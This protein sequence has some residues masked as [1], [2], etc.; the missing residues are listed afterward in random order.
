MTG[1]FNPGM[2]AV[3]ISKGIY[4][5]K[6]GAIHLEAEGKGRGGVAVHYVIDGKLDKGKITGN[7]KYENGSG[8]FAITKQ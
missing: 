3:T 6:T 7:W 2:N 5:E 8:E 1:T 4:N